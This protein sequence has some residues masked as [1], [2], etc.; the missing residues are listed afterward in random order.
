MGGLNMYYGK[1]LLNETNKEKVSRMVLFIFESFSNYLVDLRIK[2]VKP[3][4]YSLTICTNT[5]R[6]YLWRLRDLIERAKANGY[7]NSMTI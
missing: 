3:G 1:I 2:E 5:E 4:C 7:L 6:V